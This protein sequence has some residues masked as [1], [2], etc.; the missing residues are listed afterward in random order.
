MNT[1]VA[2]YVR[3]LNYAAP[4]GTVSVFGCG[5]S[6]S[7]SI[8]LFVIRPGLYHSRPLLSSGAA[9]SRVVA[10]QANRNFASFFCSIAP[11]GLVCLHAAKQNKLPIPKR[12]IWFEMS[13]APCWHEFGC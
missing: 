7:V 4:V 8:R 12:H 3:H 13:E 9:A 6:Y 10:T 2:T 11:F 1:L 5:G